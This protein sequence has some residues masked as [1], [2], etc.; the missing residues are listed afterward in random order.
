MFRPQQIAIALA[1][2]LAAAPAMAAGYEAELDPT[3]FDAVNRADVINSIGNVTAT[4]NGNVLTVQGSF[5]A[6]TSPATG[7]S[8]RI[9]LAKGVPGDAIGKLTAEHSPAGAV[10]GSVTLTQDQV[11]ALQKQA[12]YIRIDS[13]KAPEGNLQGWL[14]GK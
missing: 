3:P 4:L 9:G 12:L 13:E 5:S 7:A 6:M 8:V 11:A 14:E 2:V 10:S 1:A